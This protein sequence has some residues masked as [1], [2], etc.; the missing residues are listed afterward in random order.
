MAY[1][2]TKLARSIACAASAAIPQ[3]EA[4][5]AKHLGV[6]IGQAV[7]PFLINAGREVPA[8]A[9]LRSMTI[10]LLRE[11]RHDAI[12]DA[13]A[14]YA[15]SASS[16]LWRLRV[17]EPGTP[18][19]S[20]SGSPWDRRRL[21]E[22]LRVAGL[23]RDPAGEIARDVERRIVAL[24]EDRISRAM[25]H[26][27][28]AMT[29][30]ARGHDLRTYNAKRVGFSVAEHAQHFNPLVAVHLPLAAHSPALEA[31]WVQAVH[32]WEVA[33]AI[34]DNL[35][36]LLP[37]PRGPHS[38]SRGL[39]ELQC[40]DPLSPEAAKLLRQTIARA[41]GAA[42]VWADTP[43][44]ITALANELAVLTRVPIPNLTHPPALTLRLKSA[45]IRPARTMESA[46]IVTINL[47]GLVVREALH[48]QQRVTVR[49][50][51][52]AALAGLAHR[53][54]EEYFN[55]SPIRG[56]TLPVALVG[57]WNAAAW[58]EGEPV[59]RPR[60]TRF[61]RVLAGMCL[62]ALHTALETLRGETGMDLRLAGLAPAEATR[63]LWCR[64][65]EFFAHDGV[66]LDP[67]G[68]YE[69]GPV[70]KLWAGALDLGERIEAVR[71]LAPLF[72][73]PPLL[74]AEVPLGEEAEP[75]AWRELLTTLALTGAP[76][77][78]LLPGGNPRSMKPLVRAVRTHLEG[79]PLFEQK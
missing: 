35:L 13:Y 48:D 56:R 9:D 67:A 66:T 34:H 53:Q 7:G 70:L 72:D 50:A 20:T 2:L 21:L 57:L 32:S 43:E 54:R 45:P 59:D 31:F 65:G 47:G 36:S 74:S 39:S 76:Y 78:Q 26:A 38:V 40:L 30:S 24:G 15:R 61:S 64:D 18:C 63:Q 44:R 77:L 58:L 19:T 28:S 25:I 3:L 60:L 17:V 29:L 49:L 27:L 33:R 4:E 62:A 10:K 37:Y 68:V 79:F 42:P 8:T 73:E 23:A 14:E 41:E 16:L 52:M 11:T 71:E 1:D 55:L 12:A 46:P 5:A 75:S 6:Q 51:Q 22:S 69:T